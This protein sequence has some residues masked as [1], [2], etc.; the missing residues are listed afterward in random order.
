M[1]NRRRAPPSTQTTVP[2]TGPGAAREPPPAP[3]PRR[4]SGPPPPHHPRGGEHCIRT[5]DTWPPRPAQ[6]QA[7]DGWMAHSRLSGSR[8]GKLDAPHTANTKPSTAQQK[9]QHL[10]T[11]PNQD[12]TASLYP[13]SGHVTTE[14]Q[15]WTTADL[16]RPQ[17]WIRRAEGASERAAGRQDS[18]DMHDVGFSELRIRKRA[19]RRRTLLLV[20]LR[21]S[22]AAA[23]PPGWTLPSNRTKSSSGLG[24]QH[25]PECPES[26]RGSHFLPR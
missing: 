15:P 6:E 5:T 9:P 16:H 8:E 13:P 25:S 10:I 14:A 7:R 4:G 12:H 23:A 3:H 26:Q 21:I 2:P 19:G 24:D 11:C 1:T 20:P 17:S 18:A 22:A